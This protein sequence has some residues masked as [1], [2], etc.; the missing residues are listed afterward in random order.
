MDG[1]SFLRHVAIATATRR[2]SSNGGGKSAGL[3]LDSGHPMSRAVSRFGTLWGWR[4]TFVPWRCASWAPIVR[5]VLG[6]RL[7]A[8]RRWQA[9][10]ADAG[11]RLLPRGPSSPGRPATDG[12]TASAARPAIVALEHA[13]LRLRGALVLDDVSLT[14]ASGE[15]VYVVGPMEAGKTSLLRLIHGD[16]RPTAGRLDVAGVS[17]GRRSRRRRLLRLRRRVGVVYQERRLV[18]G[19][20]ALENVTFTLRVNNLW[21]PAREARERARARLEQVGLG[22]AANAY[23]GQ[24]SG[25]Q[26]ARLAVARALAQQPPVLVADE[27]TAGLDP[28]A[29][30]A[31]LDLLEAQAAHGTT[32][33][34]A[35]HHP[36]PLRAGVRVLWLNAGRVL[37]SRPGPTPTLDRVR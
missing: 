7:R 22:R 23:P 11:R 19:L 28:A 24:L 16:L 17:V 37:E 20:T 26:Q 34:I 8:P 36:R 30:D 4:V 18:D 5:D 14:L 9:N 10:L 21:V 13:G 25:G 3:G 31:I 29:A 12:R 32:V 27:P 1:P 6:Y 2:K 15:V 33:L 35:T